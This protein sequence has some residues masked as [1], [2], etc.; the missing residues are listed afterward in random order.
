[1][2][3]KRSRMETARGASS[4][5]VKIFP[6][7]RSFSTIGEICPYDNLVN[8]LMRGWVGDRETRRWLCSAPRS[9][10]FHRIIWPF[11]IPARV[12]FC[13]INNPQIS[14]MDVPSDLTSSVRFLLARESVENLACLQVEGGRECIINC[15][16]NLCNK[17]RRIS[18]LSIF[19][20]FCLVFPSPLSIL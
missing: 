4:R 9:H 16:D 6:F 17:W 20:L 18:Q 1:M 8:H 12:F 5:L 14:L 10:L 3:A 15:L 11:C 2:K 7:R 19:L 13:Q